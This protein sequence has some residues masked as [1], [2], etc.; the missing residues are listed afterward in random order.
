MTNCTSPSVSKTFISE[1]PDKAASPVPMQEGMIDTWIDANFSMHFSI[2]HKL[3]TARSCAS[4]QGEAF[5]VLVRDF[6][7]FALDSCWVIFITREKET[8]QGCGSYALRKGKGN[9]FYVVETK[10]RA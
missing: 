10:K 7:V 6:V 1:R 9:L 5:K 2:G 8:F 4:R 3:D